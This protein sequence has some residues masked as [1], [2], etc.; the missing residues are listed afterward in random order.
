M[1]QS[2]DLISGKFEITLDK[3]KDTGKKISLVGYLGIMLLP[4]SYSFVQMQYC[5]FTIA[6][7][8]FVIQMIKIN[9]Y[10]VDKIK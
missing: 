7:G 9:T 2:G 10:K 3:P 4:G 6:T 8:T 5:Y 1:C